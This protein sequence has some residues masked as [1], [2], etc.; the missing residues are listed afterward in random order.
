VC[1]IHAALDAP[2]PTVS[3]H[4][5][6]LR[7]CGLVDARREGTWMHYRL[8][9][10]ANPVIAGIVDAALHALTHSTTRRSDDSRLR[11]SLHASR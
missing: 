5:A 7:N 8:R 2:Q 11:R 10:P 9:T 4:L 6:Y 1:H 3:R